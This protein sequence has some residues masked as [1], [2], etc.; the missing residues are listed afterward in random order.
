MQR[1]RSLTTQAH[2]RLPCGSRRH[3]VQ[4]ATFAKQSASKL[5]QESS[6]SGSLPSN[7][8]SPPIQFEYL[9]RTLGQ[10]WFQHAIML[11]SSTAFSC[12]RKLRLHIQIQ[13]DVQPIYSGRPG[14]P[15][16]QSWKFLLGTTF[17]FFD[18][19]NASFHFGTLPKK[20]TTFSP[21]DLALA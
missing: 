17:A 8:S 12:A 19:V 5:Y 2:P 1:S 9:Q 6:L 13:S 10:L 7:C 21:N 18:N 15:A 11:Q 20:F 4:E 14:A 16:L 3:V